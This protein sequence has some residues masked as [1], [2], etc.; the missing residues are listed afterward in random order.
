VARDRASGLLFEALIRQAGLGLPVG[1][2]KPFRRSVLVQQV[3]AYLK[4][5]DRNCRTVKQ[6]IAVFGTPH[7]P[8]ATEACVQDVL[9]DLVRQKLLENAGEV[10]QPASLGWDFIESN[11]IYSNMA[12]TPVEVTLVDADTGGSIANVARTQGDTVRVAGRDYQVLPGGTAGE[13]RVRGT[14]GA[15]DSPKYH[16]VRLPYS[17]DLGAALAGYLGLDRSCLALV[18]SGGSTVVFTWLGKLLNNALAATLKSL[19]RKV[20]IGAFALIIEEI[21]S[22]DVL[23]LIQSA[24]GQVLKDNPLGATKVEHMADLGAHFKE[25]SDTQRQAARRD[26]LDREYLTRWSDNLK[27]VSTVEM[28]SELGG[29]LHELAKV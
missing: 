1:P 19:K 28:D 26:W 16:T 22:A 25:L 10:Y 29:K 23:K 12:P 7:L 24:V 20:K 15:A 13:I 6:L 17:A 4:Q 8:A 14:T 18:T 21:Q 11:R 5:V 2:L 3:L 9:A 27:D